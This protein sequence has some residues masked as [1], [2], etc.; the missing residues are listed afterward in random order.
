ME[1]INNEQQR[2]ATLQLKQHCGIVHVEWESDWML[3]GITFFLKLG[4]G[5][6]FEEQAPVAYVYHE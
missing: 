4:I 3:R 2:C 1:K 6:G 5:R